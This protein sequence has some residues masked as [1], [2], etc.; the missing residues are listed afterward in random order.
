MTSEE[1]ELA[2]LLSNETWCNEVAFL[3][4]IFQALNTLNKNMQGKNENILT[5]TDKISSFKEKL[6]LWGARIK[7]ENKA[8]MF[9]LTKNCRLDKNLVSLIL[10]SLSLLSKNIEKYFPSLG[11]SS[12]DWVRDP[13]VLNACESAVLTVA[14]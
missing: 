9:E 2:D 3:A 1:S 13:F 12:L 14:E 5:C 8:E 11:V 7:K 4:D 10:Q 6:T